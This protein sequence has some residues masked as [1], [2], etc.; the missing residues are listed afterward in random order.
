MKAV[1]K[2]KDVFVWLQTGFEKTLCYQILPFLF[3]HKLGLKGSEKSS[4]VL[5][6]SP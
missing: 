4:A 5:V 3:D 2:G 1:Y 6:V